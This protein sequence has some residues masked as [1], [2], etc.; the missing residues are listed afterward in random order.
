MAESKQSVISNK[1]L[2]I[3]GHLMGLAHYAAIA[4][5]KIDW[6]KGV[7]QEASRLPPPLL[8]PPPQMPFSF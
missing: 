3:L 2:G 8:L 6:G 7:L 1:N 5:H 4:A